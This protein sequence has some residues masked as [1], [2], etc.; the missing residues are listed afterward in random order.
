MTRDAL[1]PVLGY[2]QRSGAIASDFAP[3]SEQ[4]PPQLQDYQNY[5]LRERSL[6]SGTVEQYLAVARRLLVAQDLRVSKDIARL[7]PRDIL[8]FV[9]VDCQRYSTGTAKHHVTALRAFLRYLHITGQLT[10]DLSTVVPSVARRRLTG[11]PRGLDSHEV[12]GLLATCDRRTPA[13][14]ADYALLV[15]LVR[16]G[17]RCCEVAALELE[18]IDW[19]QGQITIRGKGREERLPL[20]EDVGQSLARYLRVR[21][22]DVDDRHVFLRRR[23]PMGPLS[24]GALK[25]IVRTHLRKAGISPP[26]PHR[27]RHTAATQMLC[28]G[29]SLDQIAQ[30]LRHHSVDTTAIY[31]KVNRHQLHELSQP[32]PEVDHA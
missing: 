9:L 24:V 25:V 29:A 21:R 14:R 22:H 27:L 10:H 8:D 20:P 17:L 3:V 12:S 23:A 6:T 30:V 4:L 7:G 32:W 5:L 13:G 1:A 26:Q 11:L 28:Q 18:D 31:A 16:L 2:L 15:L 19:R